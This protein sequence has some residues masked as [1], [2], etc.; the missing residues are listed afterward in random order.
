M[1]KFTYAVTIVL[2]VGL[3][4]GGMDCFHFSN[5][6]HHFKVLLQITDTI[7]DQR[8]DKST[9]I[10]GVLIVDRSE[11]VRWKDGSGGLS[12]TI[13]DRWDH[14]SGGVA[15]LVLLLLLSGASLS[16]SPGPIGAVLGSDIA[17]LD[18]LHSIIFFGL[19]LLSPHP[20]AA[21]IGLKC[22]NENTV[23]L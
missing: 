14:G 23:S 22:V 15:G 21:L 18:R 2:T 16:S 4:G 9:K 3:T 19:L 20:L 17:Y 8:L 13:W 10:S 6:V 5:G 1:L 11:L 7:V 12:G